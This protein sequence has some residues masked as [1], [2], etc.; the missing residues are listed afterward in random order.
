MLVLVSLVL[1]E[2][3]GIIIAIIAVAI[4]TRDRSRISSAATTRNLSV[5]IVEIAT[6]SGAPNFFRCLRLTPSVGVVPRRSE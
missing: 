5:A 1:L 6:V 3:V 2:I 4:V